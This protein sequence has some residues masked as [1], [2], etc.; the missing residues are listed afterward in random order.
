MKY[1][2]VIKHAFSE[3]LSLKETYLI[4]KGET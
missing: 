4:A 2:L 3:L 1:K